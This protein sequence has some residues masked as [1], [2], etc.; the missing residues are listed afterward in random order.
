[1][2]SLATPPPPRA[3]NLLFFPA[4][5]GG[6]HGPGPGDD[7][8]AAARGQPRRRPHLHLHPLHRLPVRQDHPGRLRGERESEIVAFRA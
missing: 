2:R 4:E 1:M 7:V 8:A 5:H 3:I 6:E